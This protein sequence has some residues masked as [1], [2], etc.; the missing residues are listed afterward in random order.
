M[1]VN[2]VDN[3]LVGGV[4]KMEHYSVP[5]KPALPT[6]GEGQENLRRRRVYPYFFRLRSRF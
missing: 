6:G 4:H 5:P 1:L 3:A 2:V